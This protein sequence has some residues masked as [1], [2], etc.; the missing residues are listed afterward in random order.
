MRSGRSGITDKLVCTQK[1]ADDRNKRALAC[2]S[3]DTVVRS[4]ETNPR[5]PKFV[6]LCDDELD[7]VVNL[8]VRRLMRPRNNTREVHVLREVSEMWG[9]VQQN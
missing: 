7:V 9:Q 4:A 3:F 8:V 5:K 1:V 6:K 2:P